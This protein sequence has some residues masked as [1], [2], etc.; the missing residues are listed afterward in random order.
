MFIKHQ[1]SCLDVSSTDKIPPESESIFCNSKWKTIVDKFCR[2]LYEYSKVK[3]YFNALDAKF[4]IL[5]KCS[6]DTTGPDGF[7]IENAYEI[8]KPLP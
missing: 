7:I 1:K 8:L 5:V 6:I 3:E 4:S 2:A